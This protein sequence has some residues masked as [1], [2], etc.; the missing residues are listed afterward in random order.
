MTITPAI[1]KV[2][3]GIAPR[4]QMYRMFDRYAQRPNRWESD[5]SPLY[6]GEWFEIAEAEHDYMFE[7]LPPLGSEARYS[8][9]ANF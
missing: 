6:A 8:R 4:Q 1:R 9:C 5:A 2:F 3:Q 7:L